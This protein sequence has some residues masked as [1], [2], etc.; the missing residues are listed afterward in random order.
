MTIAATHVYVSSAD[1]SYD[2]KGCER[3]K[4]PP[5][6]TLKQTECM[7]NEGILEHWQQYIDQVIGDGS[8]V[9]RTDEILCRG[10]R[11]ICSSKFEYMTDLSPGCSQMFLG[12]RRALR[13]LHQMMFKANENEQE[14]NN[15]A[16][17]SLRG[18]FHDYMSTDVEGSI[19]SE[20][21][22]YLHNVFLHN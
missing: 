1:I 7:N 3:L 11:G 9:P 19:L 10:Q 6:G 2:V 13:H 16:L 20:N 15:F 17:K 14:C 18:F 5:Q 8:N 12:C 4:G 22:L 21:H